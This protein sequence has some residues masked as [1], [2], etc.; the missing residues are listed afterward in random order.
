MAFGTG[1]EAIERSGPLGS[2]FMP[3]DQRPHH[4]S[5]HW[6]ALGGVGEF[7]LPTPTGSS[8][9]VPTRSAYEASAGLAV[10]TTLTGTE[11]YTVTH[12][13]NA[14]NGGFSIVQTG[15]GNYARDE[16]DT[17]DGQTATEYSTTDSNSYTHSVA[18]NDVHGQ[19]AEATTGATRYA[20]LGF[21]TDHGDTDPNPGAY[22]GA[23]GG[24]LHYAAAL[25]GR[26]LIH[27]LRQ[28]YWNSMDMSGQ[29]YDK[30][31][32]YMSTAGVVAPGSSRSALRHSL[33]KEAGVAGLVVA[34]GS[35]SEPGF[36]VFTLFSGFRQSIFF[37]GSRPFR[38]FSTLV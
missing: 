20:V 14:Q 23:I 25:T 35:S 5:P 29:W 16:W 4:G 7:A 28:N 21:T 1:D 30:P 36:S 6:C 17:P 32:Q 37:V 31:T 38:Y 10:A 34:P 8:P 2:D 18:G 19:L 27:G 12:A 15:A 13:D 22:L 11:T 9:R 3:S 33:L 24:A 26:S